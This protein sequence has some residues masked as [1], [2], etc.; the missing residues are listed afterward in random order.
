MRGRKEGS[1]GHLLVGADNGGEE[2]R[3]GDP[4]LGDLVVDLGGDVLPQPRH[5]LLLERRQR[6]HH[7]LH[8][9]RNL[10]HPLLPSP[11]FPPR[12]GCS[13]RL[14]NADGGEWVGW[15]LGRAPGC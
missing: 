15:L 11:R 5:H 10:P 13:D 1:R 4:V 7:R 9:H 2:E 3:G 12:D 14:A 6:V 8:P